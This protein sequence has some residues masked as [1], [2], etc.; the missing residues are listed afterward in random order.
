[1]EGYTTFLVHFT[2]L[3]PKECDYD[4][5]WIHESNTQGYD[6]KNCSVGEDNSNMCKDVF[7]EMKLLQSQAENH[8]HE[9]VDLQSKLNILGCSKG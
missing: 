8:L 1:M 3:W 2:M 9:D 5:T 4:Q 7:I 6:K